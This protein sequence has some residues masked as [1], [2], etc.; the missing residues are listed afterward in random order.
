MNAGDKMKKRVV[1]NQPSRRELFQLRSEAREELIVFISGIHS[2]PDRTQFQHF[3]SGSDA[4]LKRMDDY[5]GDVA[6]SE[7][8]K[9]NTAG[10]FDKKIF[11]KPSL[12]K[13]GRTGRTAAEYLSVFF[14]LLESPIEGR[15]GESEMATL[16]DALN[17]SSCN[18]GW[19]PNTRTFV[20][21]SFGPR[22]AGESLLAYLNII[23]RCGPVHGLCGDCGTMFLR[24]K[25]KRLFCVPCSGRH[26]E[27]PSRKPYLDRKKKEY[28]MR[29][30][31]RDKELLETLQRSKSKGRTDGKR[32]T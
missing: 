8:F 31:E 14:R 5:D 28:R 32:S 15:P 1:R 22:E 7:A 18:L 24:N 25:G 11:F 13:A 3:L 23:A 9:K 21:E 10:L 4:E 30:K 27:Y 16:N 19:D 2:W 29:D 17:E 6:I 12:Y 20:T 26:Q